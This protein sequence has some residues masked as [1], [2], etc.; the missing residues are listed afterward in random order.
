M[1]ILITGGAG[2]IGSHLAELYCHAG[3]QVFVIDDLSTG[4]I[5]NIEHL[6]SNP[7]FHYY[8]DTITN[9]QLLRELIDKC[10]VIVHLA[11][12]VGVQLIVE[13]PVNTIE[14]NIYGTE[15]VLQYASLKKKKVLI[16]ST[17]EVY[18]KSAND[19]FS[20][21]DDLV[22]GATTKGRWSYACSKAIDEFLAL[23]YWRERKL[24]V[25]I[26]RLFNTI[27]PRQT[28]RYGMVVPRFVRAA[29]QNQPI[30][31]YGTG[32][33]TRCF[34]NV[35]DVVRILKLLLETERAVGEIFN[36]GATEEISINA[37][38]Q[39]IKT[40]TQS[41]SDI[42]HIPYEE[43]YA[44]G[45]EDMLRRL[46]DVAK[47]QQYIGCVP[48]TPLDVTLHEVIDSMRAEQEAP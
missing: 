34:T 4:S 18:G 10:H 25:V 22:L 7:N 16:A 8:L 23:A 32:E 47:L 9:R 2:F 36:V 13:S 26:A 11:A 24:P 27:G 14:T 46:P 45:F 20:E 29:L 12:A 40:M 31:V 1:K 15:L 35:A 19:A 21:E 17:S 39:T 37:L 42:I 38:A 41:Q 33:Q 6:K 3:H 5:E 44:E 30:P 28:G 43:A 48:Q